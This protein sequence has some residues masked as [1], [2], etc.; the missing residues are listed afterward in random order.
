MCW[1]LRSNLAVSNMI[2]IHNP[3]EALKCV[4]TLITREET[5]MADLLII[6]IH[7]KCTYTQLLVEQ[8]HVVC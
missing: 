6:Y 3:I 7:I 8:M 5:A 1:Y 2:M 4:H